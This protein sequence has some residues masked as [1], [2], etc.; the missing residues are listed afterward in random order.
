MTGHSLIVTEESMRADNP[1]KGSEA[2]CFE[3][4]D[5]EAEYQTRIDVSGY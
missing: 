4:N 1:V 5:L 2:Y 3:V